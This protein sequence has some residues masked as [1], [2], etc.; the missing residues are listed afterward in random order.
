MDPLTTLE[1]LTFT[2]DKWLLRERIRTFKGRRG[3][4]VPVRSVLEEAQIGQRNVWE[5]SMRRAARHD[6]ARHPS[7]R[8]S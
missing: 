8:S 1:G 6:R 2:R 5:L 7:R 4:L 3:E